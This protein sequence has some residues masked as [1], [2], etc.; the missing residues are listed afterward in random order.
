MDLGVE[1]DPGPLT[2]EVSAEVAAYLLQD[3]LD[4]MFPSKGHGGEVCGGICCPSNSDSPPRQ[5]EDDA[6]VTCGRI[7]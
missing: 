4:V 6:T 3:E 2:R 1:Q 7:K 5:K